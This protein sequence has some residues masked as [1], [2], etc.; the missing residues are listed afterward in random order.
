MSVEGKAFMVLGGCDV[1]STAFKKPA[2]SFPY[3]TQ[4]VL[5]YNSRLFPVHALSHSSVCV[6]QAVFLVLRLAVYFSFLHCFLVFPSVL[7]CKANAQKHIGRHLQAEV[8]V[9][10][11]NLRLLLCFLGKHLASAPQPLLCLSR[12][13]FLCQVT[14]IGLPIN[15]QT[16]IQFPLIYPERMACFRLIGIHSLSG[17][18]SLSRINLLISVR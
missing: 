4:K 13:A 10:P 2:L 18:D 12:Q 15:I 17:T 5:P 7:F 11:L 16:G 1:I 6:S 8:P 14:F 9:R 3:Q